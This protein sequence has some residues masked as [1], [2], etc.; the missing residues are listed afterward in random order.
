MANRRCSGRPADA[1]VKIFLYEYLTGGGTFDGRLGGTPSGSLL[2]ADFV[3]LPDTRVDLLRDARLHDWR[4]S[5]VSVRTVRD[6]AEE[7]D[8]FCE[9]AAAVD[10]V[11]VIA[12]ESEGI[13][14]ERCC[15][16]EAL[17][18]RLISPSSDFIGI[19]ADKQRTAGALQAAGVPVPQGC[20]VDRDAELPLGFDY[21]AVLKPRFGAG[22]VD[23]GYLAAAAD[24][25]RYGRT[26]SVMRLERFHPGLP[27]SVSLLCGARHRL[28][29]PACR[30][31]IS[32]DGT[33]RYLGGVLPLDA[34]LCPRAQTLALRVLDALPPATGWIGVDL[35]LGA[36][37]GGCD[38]VVLEVNPRVTTSYVGLRRLCCGNLA[39]AMLAIARDEMIDLE[40]R[41]TAVTFTAEGR[42]SMQMD[43]QNGGI[44]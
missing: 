17:G 24:A 30:Q 44:A 23:M 13:L 19:A 7:R 5:G 28:T 29:L 21:P 41:Q 32:Q 6:V 26:A 25:R 43:E 9:L 18:V 27:A 8:S 4:L 15:W 12:P 2:A 22:S 39:A 34:A 20:A 35:V 10:A 40:W 3:A 31:S 14:Y 37:P 33:F 16:A 36:E 42:V 1:N 11:M 38:D